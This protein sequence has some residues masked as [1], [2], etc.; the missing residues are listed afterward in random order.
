MK[1]PRIT[2]GS[3]F[4]LALLCAFLLC[5][6]GSEPDGS[7]PSMGADAESAAAEQS[8]RKPLPAP[9]PNRNAYFGDLHVHT[10][11]SFDAFVFGARATPDDAYKFARG[12]PIKHP[13]GRDLQ[14]SRPLDFLAVTDHALYLGIGPEMSDPGTELGAHE[15]AVQLRQIDGADDRIVFF[16]TLVST[17]WGDQTDQ[18][19]SLLDLNL[20]RNTWQRIQDSAERHN[21]PGAFTTFIG[22]E[23]TASGPEFENLHRNVIFRGSEAPE[24]P[25]STLDSADPEDLWAW[26]D[27]LR[28]QGIESIA[29]PHNSNGSNGW[30]FQLTN[31]AGEPFDRAYI[32]RRRRNEPLV[33]ITQVKG[34]SDTHPLLSPNDEWAD[35]E[36]MPIRVAST[37]PSQPEG[38]YVREAWLNGLAMGESTGLNPYDFGVIGSS[39]SHNGAGSFQE[40]PYWSKTGLTDATPTLRGVVPLTLNEQADYGR[41][42]A[43]SD[44]GIAALNEPGNS[45][46]YLPSFARFW[47]ASG[48]AGVWA[49]S[50]TRGH[51]YDAFRRKETFATS[52]P[53]IPVRFFAG[54]GIDEQIIAT[55]DPVAAAYAVGVPMGADLLPEGDT[56]P[57]FFVWALQDTNSAP[58][59][60][61]QII[62]GW[63]QDGQA[64]E[65]VFDVACSD[66]DQV[67]LANHRC[68]DNGANVDMSTCEITREKGATELSA[69]WRDP[70][71][72]PGQRAFYYARVLENPKCRWS[73]HDAVTA[74]FG[75][76]PDIYATVQ[77]RAW[78]SP[79]WYRPAATEPA[80]E[81]A[82][83]A[84]E[85]PDGATG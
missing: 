19:D 53:R 83:P 38:S 45:E 51:I 18:Q 31:L 47:G 55:P 72:V 56:A 63:V 4:A 61:I 8:A 7:D 46:V 41:T 1:Q 73:T 68:P 85:E 36:I 59:Q 23:Y 40:K 80:V 71:F 81:A 33:E 70:G 2:R 67:N 44:V 13:D 32:E 79:I 29:I 78:S 52:G 21:D 10:L 22:Y 27:N 75:P 54:Y 77:D 74:G 16:Q 5:A 3:D 50:N 60:R 64:Q 66:S 28:D 24:L 12:E 39:D 62:K 58:L 37:L 49:E 14:L 26:M 48:L 25:F 42:I 82:E 6:C 84:E 11:F 57:A 76:R 35:F 9:N 69:V 17:L 30:M 15:L 34:T 43:D 20:T 65:R